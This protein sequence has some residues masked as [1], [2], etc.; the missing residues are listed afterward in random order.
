MW[1]FLSSNKHAAAML[2]VMCVAAV[3]AIILATTAS[4]HAPDHPSPA[5]TEDISDDPHIFSTYT[6]PADERFMASIGNG[7]VATNVFS[8]TVYMNGLYNGRAGRSHRARIPAYA[9]VRLNSTLTHFPFKP[10]YS[11]NTRDAVFKVRVDR[12]RS[13][14]TQRIY[15]HKFYTRTIV[16]QIEVVAKPHADPNFIH[17]EIWIAVQL[18]PG[19]DSEDIDFQ[20]PV[21]EV[22][23][24]RIVWSRCGDT[25]EVE[26]PMFQP[27]PTVVC[28]YWTSVPDHLVVPQHGSRV[29]T[30]AM[31]ADKNRTVA[32]TELLKVL[33]EDGEELF[34]KH[35][36]PWHKLY[37]SAGIDIEGNMKLSKIVNGIWY[38]LLSSLPSEKSY[39]PLERFFGLSPGSLARGNDEDY[40][41]HNFWDTEIWM[42][43]TILMLYPKFARELLQYRLDTAYVAAYNSRSS[44]YKGYRYPWE[45]AFTGVEVSSPCCPE[46][47]EYEQHISG[48]ISF[49]SRQYLAATRDEDWLKHGGC[50]IIT[51]IADFWASRAIINYTTGLY[52]IS[53]VM[54]PDEDHANVTNSVFTNVVAGYSLYL[55]HKNTTVTLK[56]DL[57]REHF[58]AMI[59][60]DFKCGLKPDESF[61]RFRTAFMDEGP[62]NAT[63]NRWCSEFKRG[64]LTL[65]DEQRSGR[66]TTAVTEESVLAVKKKIQENRRITYEEIQHTLHIGSASVHKILHE[67]L[68][69][70]RIV[71]RWVPHNLTEAQKQARV[72][73]CTDMIQKFDAGSSRHVYDIVTGDESW[74]YQ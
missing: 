17:H 63:I 60:Y 10:V 69:V 72:D 36:E 7:H 23:D 66:P 39:Q 4:S 56:I 47:A 28:V 9:N 27:L 21:P 70:R 43:P 67:H 5:E 62:S 45:S 19:A 20:T 71:S 32:R 38:Y 53:N 35:V 14:V 40:N 59:F 16:N 73:W 74:I 58:R 46:V 44:G 42:F 61:D 48:C 26:E 31:T 8:D 37:Y 30:F 15:A 25:K 55:A 1:Q 11:L 3:V 34:R 50:S 41:G 6:L 51:N 13:I 64:R 2:A 22:V 49:A 54:G 24:G 33:Q 12:D 57:Q 68:C 65:G 29:F 52:D 18:I